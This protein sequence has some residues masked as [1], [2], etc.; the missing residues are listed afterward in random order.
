M[1]KQGLIIDVDRVIDNY[2]KKNPELKQLDRKALA[3]ELGVNPQVFSDWKNGKT[4]KLVERLFKLK[5][6]GKCK[7]EDF[8]IEQKD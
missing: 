4:P 5:E 8:V 3:N 6:I 1:S 2:N 7:I